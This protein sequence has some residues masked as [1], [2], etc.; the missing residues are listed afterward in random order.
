MKLLFISQKIDEKD[1]DLAFTAQW[2]DAFIADGYEVTTLCLQKGEFDDRFP[3]YSLGKESGYGKLRILWRFFHKK[4][5]YLLTHVAEKAGKNP[6][7]LDPGC[8][9]RLPGLSVPAQSVPKK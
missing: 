1:D 9:I 3:V 7:Q 4:S 8:R 2:I 5:R 6:Q